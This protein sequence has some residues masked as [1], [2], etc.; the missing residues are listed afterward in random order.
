MSCETSTN[1]VLQVAVKCHLAGS[2]SLGSQ[3]ASELTLAKHFAPCRLNKTPCVESWAQH[4]PWLQ[5]SKSCIP[6]SPLQRPRDCSQ[7][8][9]YYQLEMR[10]E[11]SRADFPGKGHLS[12]NEW[13]ALSVGS[14][15]RS[16]GSQGILV[17][18]E[19]SQK[20]S[21]SR[22]WVSAARSCW[23]MDELWVEGKGRLNSS[24][25]SS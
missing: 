5:A 23:S 19:M 8:W 6:M 7:G 21:E 2:S 1:D 24:T 12:S 4:S 13:K 10:K 11:R 17:G 18:Y 16:K 14:P 15:E 9:F 25:R 20:A 3:K 22:V